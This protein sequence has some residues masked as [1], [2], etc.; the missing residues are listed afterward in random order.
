MEE[1]VRVFM[2]DKFDEVYA[3]FDYRD[4]QKIDSQLEQVFEVDGCRQ[5]KELARLERQEE[6]GNKCRGNKMS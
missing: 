3:E 5:E 1:Q 2:K 6:G 4:K